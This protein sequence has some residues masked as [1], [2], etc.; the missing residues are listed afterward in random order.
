M[1]YYLLNPIWQM[2]Y[3]KKHLKASNLC[4]IMYDTNHTLYVALNTLTFSKLFLI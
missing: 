3:K 1:F 4:P 2:I